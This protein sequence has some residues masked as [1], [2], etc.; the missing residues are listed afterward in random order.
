MQLLGKEYEGIVHITST[1]QD[2]M[3]RV[4]DLDMQLGCHA[5]LTSLFTPDPSDN[6]DKLITLRSTRS[7][8]SEM[9]TCW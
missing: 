7:L 3:Q 6:L 5:Y 1:E 4:W 2:V 9:L 8:N